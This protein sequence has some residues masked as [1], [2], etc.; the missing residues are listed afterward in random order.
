M[1]FPKSEILPEQIDLPGYGGRYYVRR[2]GTVW[3]R[4]KTKDTRIEGHRKGRGR[5][6]KLMHPE[7]GLKI[8]TMSSIMK[9]TYFRNL[10]ENYVLRHVNG[11]EHDWSYDNLQPVTRSELGKL[12][13]RNHGSRS[14][15]KVD[16]ETGEVV[17]I[18]SSAREAGRRNFCSYQ[19]ILDACNQV[20]KKRKGKAPDGYL[21]RWD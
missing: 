16:P 7:H 1:I 17:A 6:M 12:T 4:Y 2:D 5:E 13:Y 10:P 15:L 18:Y 21:Y 20:N 9:A 19:T 14:V 8:T 11:L 3:R